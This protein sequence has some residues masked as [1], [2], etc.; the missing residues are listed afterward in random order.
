[1]TDQTI[2]LRGC[3]FYRVAFFVFIVACLMNAFDSYV[4]HTVNSYLSTGE[5]GSSHLWDTWLYVL[6]AFILAI[7]GVGLVMFKEMKRQ[8]KK[9]I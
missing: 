6:L 8:L 7:E 3:T 9:I 2:S 5:S 4:S 1:M